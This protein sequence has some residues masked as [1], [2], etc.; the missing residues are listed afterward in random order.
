MYHGVT[1]E[2]LLLISHSIKIDSCLPWTNSFNRI[3]VLK[4]DQWDT[5]QKDSVLIGLK[6][7]ASVTPLDPTET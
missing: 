7:E 5:F 3:E 6:G 1:A 2:C 4:L